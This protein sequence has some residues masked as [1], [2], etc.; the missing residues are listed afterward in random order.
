L[1][2]AVKSTE[3]SVIYLERCCLIPS[4]YGFGH[5]NGAVETRF[6]SR[7]SSSWMSSAKSAAAKAGIIYQPFRSSI[8]ANDALHQ[9]RQRASKLVTWRD[10]APDFAANLV[11]TVGPAG[12]GS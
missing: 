6:R 10:R 2:S 3:T 7:N 1:A 8:V 9:L 4:W 11:I 12:G 5:R